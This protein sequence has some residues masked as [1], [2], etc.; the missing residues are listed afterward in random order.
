MLG[1]MQLSMLSMAFAFRHCQ[2]EHDHAAVAADLLSTGAL[3][4]SQ[5]V[6]YCG[7][8]QKAAACSFTVRLQPDMLYYLVVYYPGNSSMT[9]KHGSTLGLWVA[10]L[11]GLDQG[12]TSL[13][14]LQ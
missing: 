1:V 7:A 13:A 3:N 8:G 10:Q 11:Q 12:T 14:Q 5:A 6:A 9:D 4:E 2:L